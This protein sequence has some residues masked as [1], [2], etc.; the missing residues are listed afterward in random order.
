MGEGGAGAATPV[1]ET[2]AAPAAP[3]AAETTPDCGLYEMTLRWMFDLDDGPEW[4]D[5]APLQ[6]DA[7]DAVTKLGNATIPDDLI[8]R[9]CRP[10]ASSP[11]FLSSFHRFDRNEVGAYR[12]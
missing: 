11:L 1:V 2:P 8:G 6:A 4:T 9:L 3:A 5:V 12:F 10:F 7:V